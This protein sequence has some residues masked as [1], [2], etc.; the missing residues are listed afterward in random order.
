LTV[1]LTPEI[2]EYG[3]S[4]ALSDE[5]KMARVPLV[6]LHVLA[7]LARTRVVEAVE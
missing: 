5:V 2:A 1:T 6:G 3:T 4:T 7:E